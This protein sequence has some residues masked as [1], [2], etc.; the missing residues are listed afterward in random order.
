MIAYIDVEIVSKYENPDEFIKAIKG[1]ADHSSGWE[2]LAKQSEEYASGIGERSCMLLKLDNKYGSTVAITVK[3]G[4]VFYIANIAPKQSN[5]ISMEE[6]NSVANQLA[7]DIRAYAKSN[8]LLLAI[9]TTRESIGLP[10]IVTGNKTRA[11]FERYLNLHPR[12]YHFYDIERLDVSHAGRGMLPRSKGF[13]VA[14]K[15]R[16]R[17]N[18]SVGVAYPDTLRVTNPVT[19]RHPSHE[20]PDSVILHPGY[21]LEVAGVVVDM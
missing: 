1:F 4:N 5:Q 13:N 11:F 19:L 15:H 21:S 6:Y 2:F 9:K 12:S 7:T 10:E 17:Q 20:R 8:K 16:T 14:Q 18:V 3:K